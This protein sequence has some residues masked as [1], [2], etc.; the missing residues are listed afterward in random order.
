LWVVDINGTVVV[1]S[2]GL[3]HGPTGT[4]RAEF[5]TVLDSIRIERA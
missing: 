1:I 4:A 3:E 2:T 5:A